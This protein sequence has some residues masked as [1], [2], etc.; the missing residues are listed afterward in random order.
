MF[1]F[2]I[3]KSDWWKC[4]KHVSSQLWGVHIFDDVCNILGTSYSTWWHMNQRFET[5][6][7]KTCAHLLKDDQKPNQL[8]LWKGPQ[9]QAKKEREFHSKFRAGDESWVCVYDPGT[10][11]QSSYWKSHPSAIQENLV[12][13]VRLQEHVACFLEQWG[14]SSEGVFSSVPRCESAVLHSSSKGYYGS[15]LEKMPDKWHT[16]DWLLYCDKT[17]CHTHSWLFPVP[18]PKKIVVVFGLYTSPS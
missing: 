5:D 14:S 17:R 8:A 4:G 16:Q 6:C 13:E 1:R 18:N 10:K 12:D 3:I 7:C 11:Q 2:S 15:C 9:E